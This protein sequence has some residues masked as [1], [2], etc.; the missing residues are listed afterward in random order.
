MAQFRTT[1][2]LYGKFSDAGSI[3]AELLL[4]TLSSV[5]E[6]SNNL[7]VDYSNFQEHVYFNSAELKTEAAISKHISNYPIGISGAS[8]A[9]LTTSDVALVDNYTQKLNGFEKFVLNYLGGVTGDTILYPNPTL[10]AG[11]VGLSGTVP[12]IYITRDASNAV[13]GTQANLSANLLYLAQVYDAGLN[14]IHLMSGTAVDFN[15]NYW[16][17]GTFYTSKVLP[18]SVLQSVNRQSNMIDWIPSAYFVGDEDLDTLKRFMSVI[19]AMFDDLKLYVNQ[20]ANLNHISYDNYNRVPDGEIM[21]LLA[22]HFGFHLVDTLLRQDL[23][24]YL[25]HEDAKPPLYQVAYKMWNRVLNN[26]I[27]LYK[28]KGTLESVRALV[29]TYGLPDTYLQI[30]DYSWHAEPTWQDKIEYKNVRT[31]WFDGHSWLHFD[32]SAS[33]SWVPAGEFTYEL[34]TTS[35]ALSANT[36]LLCA[37]SNTGG[38]KILFDGNTLS[39][40]EFGSYLGTPLTASFGITESTPGE[41][42]NALSSFWT[43]IFVIRRVYPPTGN[44]QDELWITWI[45]DTSVSAVYHSLSGRTGSPILASLSSA[46]HNTYIGTFSPNGVVPDAGAGSGWVGYIQEIKAF[47]FSLAPSDIFEH[48]ENYESMSWQTTHGFY[49]DPTINE[50]WGEWKLKENVVLSGD[51]YVVNSWNAPSLTASGGGT[52]TAYNSYRM[53][54]GM[55]KETQIVTAGDFVE[56]NV[57]TYVDADTKPRKSNLVHVGFR[58]TYAV[59][60]DIVNV[61]GDLNVPSIIGDPANFY[62]NSPINDWY[63]FPNST[64]SAEMVF[65]RYRDKTGRPV[66][67]GI[68]EYIQ[69]LEN[70]SPVILGIFESINQLIP[71]RSLILNRGVTIEPHLLEHSRIPKPVDTFTTEDIPEDIIEKP[72]SQTWTDETSKLMTLD[73]EESLSGSP[74]S[75]RDYFNYQQEQLPN[76][77]IHSTTNYPRIT[78]G[79][80]IL[81]FSRNVFEP[82]KTFLL[83]HVNRNWVNNTSGLTGWEAS[84][85]GRIQLV[86]TT[87]G[88]GLD[89]DEVCMRLDIPHAVYLDGNTITA[90]ANYF[91]VRVNNTYVSTSAFVYDYTMQSKRGLDIVIEPSSQFMD[92][93]VGLLQLVVT[94][95][96][97]GRTA[98]VP[99]IVSTDES[100]FGG[101]LELSVETQI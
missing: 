96:L 15:I 101:T 33:A 17:D 48:T 97:S 88:K 11:A 79:L 47:N 21:P 12:L 91:N 53:I 31:L 45:D 52:L 82:D 62:D 90:T 71:V 24:K 51:R 59:N 85:T 38:I 72:E 42:R 60:N 44:T 9:T 10:T 95:L 74:Q 1:D 68:N 26:L 86:R 78:G 34:R 63:G 87:T 77:N 6:A 43:N 14:T 58:P 50:V 7:P 67:L 36:Y 54:E 16:S 40:W 32:D 13:S 5:R 57:G 39:G 4:R 66:R 56:D 100:G 18:S 81:P 19:G 84:I 64:I 41:I 73:W 49:S 8:T 93:K 98:R 89:A 65:S 22:K 99:I 2:Q 28:K 80:Q 76:V 61:W 94:N 29:R 35:S 37:G 92:T 30:D 69:A 75:T 70:L 83:I 23:S 46:P 3:S 25:R 27:Y 20:F 55:R